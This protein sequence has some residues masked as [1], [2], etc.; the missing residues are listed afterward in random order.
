MKKIVCKNYEELSKI[1]A[2]IIQEQIIAKPNSVL[3]LTTGNTP[4]GTYKELISRY[5]ENKI[6]FSKIKTPTSLLKLHNDLT[7]VIDEEANS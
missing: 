6:D 1:A 5:K 3:G 4:K 7:I 2:D